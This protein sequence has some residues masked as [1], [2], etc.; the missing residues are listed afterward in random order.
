M[1]LRHLRYFVTLAEELHFARAAE[2]LGI[3]P[4][5]LTVQIQEIERSLSARLFAR[6]K[7]SVALTPAGTIF[8]GEARAVLA[9]FAQAESAGRRAGR[10]EIG[11]IEIGYVGSAAYASVLQAQI[12]QYRT[13]WPGVEVNAHEL[14]MAGLPISVA[15]GAID[16]GFVRLPLPLPAGVSS[17]VLLRD[18]FCVALPAEHPLATIAG[19]LRPAQLAG[20]AFIPPEQA[21][22]THEVARRGRFTPRIMSG[23]G[24]LIAVLAQVSLGVGVSILPSVVSSVVRMPNLMFRPL[25]GEPIPSEV[26]AIF[27]TRDPSP[28]VTKLV[29]QLLQAPPIEMRFRPGGLHPDAKTVSTGRDL[30]IPLIQAQM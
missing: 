11:R 17:H 14:P 25:A 21:A 8:L 20:E 24:N 22:G 28:T 5:T 30:L 3:A 2:R 10:G 26:A 15:T 12:R 16:I 13:S 6:T 7:R 19:S 29:Q 18:E 4:P 27:R 9:R 23:P 1:E